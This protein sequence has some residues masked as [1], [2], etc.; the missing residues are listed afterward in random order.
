MLQFRAL[1]R[2]YSL[3]IIRWICGKV[4]YCYTYIVGRLPLPAIRRI[5]VVVG[6]IVV[7]VRVITVPIASSP[8]VDPGFGLANQFAIRSLICEPPT[9]GIHDVIR[10]RSIS[11]PRR[12]IRSIKLAMPTHCLSFL[13]L[14]IP[15][16][17]CS[18]SNCQI[19]FFYIFIVQQFCE[20][21]LTVIPDRLTKTD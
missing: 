18:L 16:R 20:R 11:I 13:Y 21:V 9:A 2:D 10:Q 4:A 14:I 3:P 12:V 6:A 1:P 15:D 5:A 7:M 19:V 8:D 17:G